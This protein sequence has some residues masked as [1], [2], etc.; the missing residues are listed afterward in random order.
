MA[1]RPSRFVST[2][3]AESADKSTHASR[4]I[5]KYSLAA[6]V[7]GILLQLGV[8]PRPRVVPV[9]IGGCGRDAEGIRC[10][11]NRQAGEVANLGEAR[12]LLGGVRI[13]LLDGRQDAGYFF[14]TSSRDEAPPLTTAP[15]SR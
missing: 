14:S 11:G 8:E 5:L 13:A 9:A 6:G 4:R 7:W 3:S 15:R 1:P 10:L 2:Y 12:E